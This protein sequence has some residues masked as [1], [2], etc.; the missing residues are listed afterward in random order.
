MPWDFITAAFSLANAMISLIE[1]EIE[2]KNRKKREQER[3]ERE[4]IEREARE[5]SRKR[6]AIAATFFTLVIAGA[7]VAFKWTTRKKSG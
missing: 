1:S 3:I 7:G 2:R 5:R 4:R 6:R